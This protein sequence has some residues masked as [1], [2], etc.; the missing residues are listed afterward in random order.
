VVLVCG[1]LFQSNRAFGNCPAPVLNEQ[2]SISS[3]VDG[4]TVRLADRQL[5]RLIGIN[6]PEIHH[7]G[8]PSEPLA[9]AAKHFLSSLLKNHKT[10][11][12]A[13]EA[14]THD[15]YGRR[16][17]HVFVSN[18]DSGSP[19]DVQQKILEKG[20]G[21]WVAIP[22]NTDYLKCYRSAE[23]V[24]RQ[25]HLGVWSN[26]Y[27]KPGN[28]SDKNTLRPGFQRLQGTISKI[29]RTKKSVWLKFNER[30]ALRIATKDLHNFHMAALYALKG[31]NLVARG[32]LYKYK[33]RLIMAIR[34]PAAME[35]Q[36]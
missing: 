10:V 13:L 11:G 31:K 8:T 34:V 2:A 22:P 20:L 27:F 15:H 12:L 25:K 26:A 21:F 36:S 9:Q 5:V 30:V 29:F 23:A 1:A 6:A 17:A 19:V 16:L 14:E 4:D 3:I 24:A 28:A 32:W 7:D 33:G 35:L 18:S